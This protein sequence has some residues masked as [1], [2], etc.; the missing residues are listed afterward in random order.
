M[1]S[2]VIAAC[3][4]LFVSTPAMAGGG[5]FARIGERAA[6][7]QGTRQGLREA[8]R[9]RAFRASLNA[10][11]VVRRPIVIRRPIVAPIYGFGQFSDPVYGLGVGGCHAGLGFYSY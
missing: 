11:I 8:A 2:I 4:V 1:R 5:L 3:L 7:R 9:E 10:P 6:I